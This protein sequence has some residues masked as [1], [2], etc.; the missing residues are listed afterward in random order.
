VSVMNG[1]RA[2]D[3]AKIGFQ[4][5]VSRLEL[6]NECQIRLPSTRQPSQDGKRRW[7]R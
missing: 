2:S 3:S 7:P 5:N 4:H 1:G 6:A